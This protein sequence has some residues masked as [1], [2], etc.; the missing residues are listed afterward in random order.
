MSKRSKGAILL[1][2]VL[3]ISLFGYSSYAAGGEKGDAFADCPKCG[4]HI[5]VHKCNNCGS[6][7]KF[8]KRVSGSI[9]CS[10]CDSNIFNTL[11]CPKCRTKTTKLGIE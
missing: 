11:T 6:T 2:C 4:Y 8:I 7:G 5:V 1:L 10:N 9:Q 3:V